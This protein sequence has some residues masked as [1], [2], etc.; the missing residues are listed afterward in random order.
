M[1][2]SKSFHKD[3]DSFLYLEMLVEIA[4]VGQ[5]EELKQCVGTENIEAI[6]TMCT[7]MYAKHAVSCAFFQTIPADFSN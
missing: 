6:M 3:I 4:W 1:L 5:T 7:Y 2:L